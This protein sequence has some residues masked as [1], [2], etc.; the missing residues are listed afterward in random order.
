MEPVILQDGLEDGQMV[1]VEVADMPILICRIDGQ[2][3]AVEDRCSHAI[4]KLSAGR[5]R[6]NEVTCPLHGARFDVRDGRCTAPPASRPI[7]TFPVTL[8]GG[9]V[10]VTVTEST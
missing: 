5:F 1:A 9:K 3:Y 2:Y 8:E 10:N 4:Q 6:G 7:K